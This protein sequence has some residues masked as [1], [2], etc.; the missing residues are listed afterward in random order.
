MPHRPSPLWLSILTPAL[1]SL[2]ACGADGASVIDA[3]DVSTGTVSE[4][5]AAS[6][7]NIDPAGEL[8]AD[9]GD[10]EVAVDP[11]D[12]ASNALLVSNAGLRVALAR[13]DATTGLYRPS[14]VRIIAG[15]FTGDGRTNGPEL[16]QQPAGSAASLGVLYAG[17]QGVHGIWRS[18]AAGTAWD[19]F[20]LDATGASPPGAPRPLAGTSPGWSASSKRRR[21][22][23]PS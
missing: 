6:C 14:E 17:P 3:P 9:F 8:G 16:A 13:L 1:L 21:P 11:E 5:L 2:P 22:R 18:G 10:I 15:N 20:T 12:P 4:R 7:Q 23:S 19:A